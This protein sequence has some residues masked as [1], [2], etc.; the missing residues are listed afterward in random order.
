[1][2]EIFT[3]TD[4]LAEM[5]IQHARFADK[6]LPDMRRLAK[7]LEAV[8]INS[9]CSKS[10]MTPLIWA[11]E[12]NSP[13]FMFCLARGA[14][15]SARGTGNHDVAPIDLA[16]AKGLLDKAD[17]LVRGGAPCPPVIK[18]R[19]DALRE[20]IARYDKELKDT[21]RTLDRALEDKS[22]LMVVK[23]FETVL[24]VKAKKM[25]G[26]R[27]HLSYQNVAVRKRAAESS[28]TED[29]WLAGLQA[30][31]SKRG[32]GLF[33]REPLGE[34]AKLEVCIAPTVAKR[35]IVAISNLVSDEGASPYEKMEKGDVLDALDQDYPFQLLS[36][37]AAGVV[38]KLDALPPDIETF[39]ERLFRLC[40]ELFTDYQLQLNADRTATEITPPDLE[41]DLVPLLC[42]DLAEEAGV[43]WLPWGVDF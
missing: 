2:S 18:A 36:C 4:L 37:G 33:T 28:L 40:P 21:Q 19:R 24:G 5:E 3:A 14:D 23:E 34:K 35:Q 39:A 17:S 9:A 22:F 20:Q 42:R 38:G 43:F 32:A 15:V 12:H 25:R 11:I 13:L 1:M 27:G 30:Q 7:M 16:I 6:Q 10:G 29:L 41:R 31:A 26:R 8:D